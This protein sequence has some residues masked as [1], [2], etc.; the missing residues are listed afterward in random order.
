MAETHALVRFLRAKRLD[1]NAA[2][3][4]LEATLTWRQ[5]YLPNLE[6]SIKETL[7]SSLIRIMPD[8]TLDGYT[9]IMVEAN[10]GGTL[11]NEEKVIAF[12]TIIIFIITIWREATDENQTSTISLIL[13]LRRIFAFIGGPHCMVD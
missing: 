13:H 4:S 6:T 8:N 10:A 12:V 2:K 11:S 9:A 1:V 3:Q 7:E 5:A